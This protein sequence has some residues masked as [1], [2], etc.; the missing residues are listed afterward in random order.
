MS[1]NRDQD[2]IKAFGVHLRTLREAN[3]LT[4]EKLAELS[5]VT[6]SQI[7]RFERGVRS[8]TLSTLKCL[9]AGLN[10]HPKELLD[11]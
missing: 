4:Q 11:F 9:A 3:N 1:T 6:F 8:P 5:G 10:I 2:Y 7:G